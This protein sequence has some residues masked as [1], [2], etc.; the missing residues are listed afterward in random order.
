MTEKSLTAMAE[1]ADRIH[2]IRPEKGKIAKV[3]E[4][5]EVALLREELTKLRTEIS[6]ISK[7]PRGRGRSRG[8]S[9]SRGR[10]ASRSREPGSDDGPSRTSRIFVTDK[11][12][13]IAFLIDNGA[14]VNVFPRKRVGGHLRKNEYELYAA[15]NTRIITY[16]TMA[17]DLDLSLRGSFKWRM[18]VADIDTPIIG[19]DF[20]IYYGLLV[21]P[22]NKR[23]IDSETG[24]TTQGQLTWDKHSSVRTIVEPAKHD[25]KHYIKTTPGPPEFCRP[26]RLA[27]D[28]YKQAKT[29]F[30]MMMQQGIIRPS[31]SPW[32]SPLHM[33][34]KKDNGVRPCG[35]Y[36][37]LNA[38]TVPDRYPVPHIE[39][40]ARTLHGRAVF[41]TIDLVR[42]YHQIPVAPEDVEKTAVTTPFG[43][44]EFL[45]TPFGLRNAA[46][47]FQLFI[48]RVLS[49]LDFCYAYIDAILVASKD[50]LE[51]EEH[52]RLLFKRLSEYGLVLNSG[53]CIFG[54]NQIKFLGYIVDEQGIR[55][56]PERVEAIKNFPKP[57]TVK[58]LRQFLGSVNFYRR[59]IPDAAKIQP[60]ATMLAHPV[61]G[62]ALSISVDAS[63]FAMGAVLQQLVDEDCRIW[64]K[65][66]IPCQRAKVT[67]HVTAPIGKFGET[68]GRFEHVHLDI[69]GPLPSFLGFRY[70]VTAVDRF[71][72]WPEAIPVTDIE[73]ATIAR[74]FISEWISRFGI[75]LKITTDQGRQFES[76]LFEELTQVI[77][78]KHLRTTAYHPAS[79]GMVERLH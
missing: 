17:V 2:E 57:T 63:D 55:P 65:T 29:E 23:L 79:N 28:R 31:K 53:K 13:K 47:T 14:D 48:D 34:V 73:A 76:K 33:A 22:K 19:M 42:A 27:P 6:A 25:V 37:A 26:R 62:A 32:A 49:G 16:G 43:L 46:Q 54:E 78:T 52:L 39:D 77:G 72:R 12:T 18:I 3:S 41:S 58:N 68:D 5:S 7:G 50:H 8:R 71:T 35:D 15:N 4:N 59:F 69:V 74:V 10:N 64:A 45:C 30:D 24:L 67:R 9:Q 56:D 38:R 40:F 44:F 20:L 60:N 36:R 75:P 21:D 51:H 70:C 11:M 61:T 1:M 66:C